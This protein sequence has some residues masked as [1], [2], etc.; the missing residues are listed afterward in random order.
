MLASVAVVKVEKST[1][2]AAA[3]REL[4]QREGEGGEEGEVE[5][6]GVAR[7]RRGAPARWPPPSAATLSARV[8][9]SPRYLPATKPARETGRASAG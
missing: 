1:A 6:A 3:D 7:G 2:S 8:A 5:E 4:H 9:S